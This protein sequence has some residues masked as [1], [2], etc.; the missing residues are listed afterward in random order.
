MVLH[1][2]SLILVEWLLI[3]AWFDPA[4][5]RYALWAAVVVLLWW[6]AW[7]NR[8]PPWP[9]VPYLRPIIYLFFLLLIFPW[10]FLS[11][12]WQAYL[13]LLEILALYG[14][15]LYLKRRAQEG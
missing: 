8:N 10:V 9:P 13:V 7:R 15:E 11:G 5:T 6:I 2:V 3:I 4:K 12:S 14:L 1:I